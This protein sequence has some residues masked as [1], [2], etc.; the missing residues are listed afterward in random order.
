MRDKLHLVEKCYIRF[1]RIPKNE[2]IRI[3]LGKDIRFEV[4]VSVWD[5]VKLEDGYHLVAPINGNT[6]ILIL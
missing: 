1:G 4:G 2:K 3:H 5:S 6:H